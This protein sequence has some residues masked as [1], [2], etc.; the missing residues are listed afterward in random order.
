MAL[1]GLV[2]ESVAAAIVD[3]TNATG[4]SA[5]SAMNLIQR[6]CDLVPSPLRRLPRVLSIARDRGTDLV[7]KRVTCCLSHTLA[8][9]ESCATC[10]LVDDETTRTRVLALR[11]PGLARGLSLG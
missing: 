11:T 3:A 1:W 7:R 6:V 10:S 9:Q 5:D 4:T 8:G 2:A